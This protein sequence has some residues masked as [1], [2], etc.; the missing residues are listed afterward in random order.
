RAI[1]ATPVCVTGVAREPTF[2]AAADFRATRAS[3]RARLPL[4]CSLTEVRMAVDDSDV[5]LVRRACAA[6]RHLPEVHSVG[7]GGRTRGGKPTGERVLVVYVT[8]KRP[9][10]ELAPDALVPAE[11]EGVPTDVFQA[12]GP[13]LAAAV[14]GAQLGGPYSQDS[15]RYRPL[16]GGV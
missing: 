11:F 8:T 3:D 2:R 9:R 16:R 1:T 7:I 14:P 6:F 12:P 5:A 15:G 4:D 10:E 13:H